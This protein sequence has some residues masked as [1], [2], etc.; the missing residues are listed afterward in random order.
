MVCIP[1]KFELSDQCRQ[2][3]QNHLKEKKEFKVTCSFIPKEMELE[4]P[5]FPIDKLIGIDN[6]SR[7]SEESKVA[8]Q[9]EKNKLLWAKECL[10]WTPYNS[11]RDFY[12]YYQKEF[13][14]C[15]AQNRVMRFGRRLGKC[16]HE[17]TLII[18]ANRGPIKAKDI[19][20]ADEL[21]TF[22]EQNG[23]LSTTRNWAIY[24][25]G[26]KD[27]L[28]IKT[29][30]GKVDSVTT[31]H[32]YLV[33]RDK[34]P[35]WVEAKDLSIGDRIAVPKN[36]DNVF[37]NNEE[38]L[39]DYE[40]YKLLGYLIADGGTNYKHGVRFTNF[41]PI[42]VLDI[43]NIVK[44][45]NCHLTRYDKGNYG[46]T[47]NKGTQKENQV[48]SLIKQH[49]L[50]CLAINKKIPEQI[51]S[52]S[53]KNLSYFISGMYD[54]DGW[55]SKTKKGVQIGYCSASE[56]MIVGLKHLLIRFGIH[57]IVSKRRVKYKGEYDHI[58][59]M[60]T[61]DNVIDAYKF[62]QEIPLLSKQEKLNN[63][64][65]SLQTTNSKITSIPKSFLP[66]LKQKIKD[67]K[68]SLNKY[69]FALKNCYDPSLEKLS[70]INEKIQLKELDYLLNSDFLFDEVK[71]IED[72]GKGQTYAITVPE[73]HTFVTNDIITH[74]TEVMTVD[75][76]HYG[77]INHGVK[78][79]VIAPFQSL[80]D[81]IFDRLDTLLSGKNSIFKNKFSR[82]KQPCEITLE[83]GT[84]IKGFTTG[85]DG[86]SIRGQSADRVYLDEAA[87]IPVEAFKAVMAFKLDNPNVSFNAASTPSALE[88]NFKAW[89]ISDKFWKS[90]Y[91]PSTILPNFHE[92]DE[93]ELRNS[94]TEDGYQLEVEAKFIEGSARVFKSHNIQAAKQKYKYINSREELEDPDDWY[95]TIG[96]DY[97]EFAHGVQIIVLG[98]KHRNC[99]KKPFRVLNRTSLH[100]D[101]TGDRRKN[102]QTLGVETIKSFYESFKADYVY[103]DQG[104]GSMQ[105]EILSE[106]FY[107]RGVLD[108]FKGVDFA[109]NYDIEDLY[110]N[111][112][113]HK[114]MKVMMVYFLQKRFELE[115]IIIS[116]TEEVG[117]GSLIDQLMMYNIIRYDSKGQ[118]IFDGEDHII[119]A[120]MLAT[121][122]FI[123]N[124]E[125]IFDRRTGSFAYSVSNNNGRFEDEFIKK[126]RIEQLT[127]AEKES[128]V[129][130][131]IETFGF[132]GVSSIHKRKRRRGVSDFEVF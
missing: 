74:N 30:T 5:I 23:K 57:A 1:L 97:N 75:M 25:N 52:A 7:L 96:V 105:N 117:K 130:S 100:N 46:I 88:T 49:N 119:D 87:Y 17:D 91:Y 128:K 18:T 31:N 13:L 10:G 63:I 36:Y 71:E 109:S 111:E 43:K 127:L 77:S 126:D 89:C 72:I 6:Y 92:K 19:G 78:I 2:C 98:F 21:I 32:P 81:E 50:N 29:R 90:F 123:E 53:K 112:I 101:T 45:Y 40:K 24:D 9:L 129:N 27:C 35:E 58:A 94:L 14:L 41:S 103:V 104:H 34:M 15:N 80:I 42:T 3:I 116:E 38:Q 86:N 4:N 28:K 106:Y 67:K 44:K 120:L 83:N 39:F 121:F 93:P 95:I 124:Y 82:K 65:K 47:R 84:K 16:V 8:L 122:A 48:I 55:I 61:I 73:T 85:T 102:L 62:H 132:L 56:D 131:K 99:G 60:L 66:F 11:K 68:E 51:Y 107:N 125:T 12:Q 20:N 118:P 76:L 110:T 64:L 33:I 22:D 26:I 69:G 79:L 70:R 108:K 54:C 114:R 59:Y 115:E 37:S 113:K